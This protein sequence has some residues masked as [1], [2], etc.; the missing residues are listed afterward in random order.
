MGWWGQATCC[1]GMSEIHY[2]GI[3]VFGAI[4]PKADVER[5]DAVEKGKREESTRCRGGSRT[6]RA[7]TWAFFVSRLR[8]SYVD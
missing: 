6:A 4:P 1:F 7:R 5:S 2:E 3:W 8:K